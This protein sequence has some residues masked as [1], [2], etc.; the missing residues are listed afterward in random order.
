MSDINHNRMI[1]LR[2]ADM[3]VAAC[4]AEITTLKAEVQRLK[5][6]VDRLTKAGDGIVEAMNECCS[7]RYTEEDE[8][9]ERWNAAKEGKPHA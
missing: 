5:A 8:A 9:I 6:E 4:E 7:R 1:P 2:V 3:A